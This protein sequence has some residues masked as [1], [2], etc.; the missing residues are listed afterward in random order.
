M[1]LLDNAYKILVSSRIT[2]KSYVNPN[3]GARVFLSAKAGNW[4]LKMAECFPAARTL[5]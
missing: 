4:K 2:D 5:C 1:R 3:A